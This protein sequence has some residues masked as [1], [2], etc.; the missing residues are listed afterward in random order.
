M[1]VGAAADPPAHEAADG[2]LTLQIDRDVR[3]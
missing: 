3:A 1:V 2:D